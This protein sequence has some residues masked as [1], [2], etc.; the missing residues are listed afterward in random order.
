M[1][2]R[3]RNQNKTKKTTLN[4]IRQNKVEQDKTINMRQSSRAENT[5]MRRKEQNRIDVG[6][7]RYNID[8]YINKIT[9][10]YNI[11]DKSYLD[12]IIIEVDKTGQ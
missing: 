5:N 10:K 7:K 8:T 6:M 11:V 1:Y 4:K 3:W 12:K 2:R 9:I